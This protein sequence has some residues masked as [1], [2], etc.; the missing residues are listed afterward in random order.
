MVQIAEEI[1]LWR[2]KLMSLWPDMEIISIP[3]ATSTNQWM[4]DRREE[5][6]HKTVLLLTDFQTAGR[7]SGTNHWES[8]EGM[9]LTFSLQVYPTVLAATHMFALSEAMSLGVCMGLKQLAESEDT[10]KK[11]NFRVK[12]PNDVYYS[13]EKICGM[14][15][16][17]DLMARQ[18]DCSIIGVGINVN[19][20]IFLSGA[21]NPTSLSMLVGHSMC[22]MQVLEQVLRCF[23]SYYQLIE[24][25]DFALLHTL[26]LS[27]VYRWQ[28]IH[29]FTDR[30]GDFE[31]RIVNVQPDG[32]LILQ[33][34]AGMER[35]YVF[36]EIKYII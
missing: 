25:G 22:R 7:G 24:C 9:N 15:I 30:A 17:N 4:R 29:R 35:K 12:W 8:Q 34:S 16:E 14:L 2:D 23:H 18:V 10:I 19:Q 36:G 31:A 1:E 5:L 13:D 28:E 33:D 11:E 6:R 32:H 27:Q 20:N 3:S 26:Y 21:P